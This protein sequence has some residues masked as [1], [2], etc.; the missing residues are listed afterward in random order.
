M[1]SY[2]SIRQRMPSQYFTSPAHLRLN[3]SAHVSTRHH[4]SA[5][6][7]IRQHTSAYVSIRQHT[8]AYVSIRQHTSANLTGVGGGVASEKASSF[9]DACA[10]PTGVGRTSSVPRST[11]SAPEKGKKKRHIRRYR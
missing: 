7:S 3:M 2:V 9:C 1:S 5:Y 6:V 4:T 8:S 11:A 10:P